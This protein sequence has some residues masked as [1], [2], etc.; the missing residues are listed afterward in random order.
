M[1]LLALLLCTVATLAVA[2]DKPN[3]LFLFADDQRADAV[4]AFNPAV[5]T[6]TLDSL[7]ERGFAFTN[8]HC[9][10][11][12]IPAICTPSRNMLLSGRAYFRWAPTPEALKA[13][14]DLAPADGPNFAVAFKNAGYQTYHHGKKGNTALNIQATFE[15]NKYLK[16]DEAERTSG[17]PGKEI[18][19]DAI[20]FLRDR[21]AA[22]DARPFFMYLA[23]ANPHDP[24]VAHDPYMAQYD[25]AKIP[26]P[27]NYLPQHPWNIGSNTV[28][29]ELLAPFPRTPEDIRKH[30]H[31]YYAVITCFDGYL[32]KILA[33]V[34]ELGLDKNTIV[35]FSADHGLGMGSHGLMGKQNIY[36]TGMKA[37]LIFAG[38]GVPHGRSDAMCY[39]L[40]ILPTAVDLAGA[41]SPKDIDG[42]SLRPVIEGRQPQVRDSLFLA[43]ID[44]QR[45]V[46]D[47]RWK[48]IVYPKIAK[49]ELFDLVSD[50]DEMKNLAD[51]PG[52][53]PRIES[54][55]A[56]LR[57]WQQHLGDTTPLKVEN[58]EPAEFIAP[59]K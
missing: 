27:K 59:K 54:L 36:E 20:A 39:L 33:T 25:E 30:L 58:P 5:K 43:Y 6:P 50:P 28:R 47:E 44:S 22:R 4:G 16:N 31:D 7:V 1:R 8:A 51:D 41:A 24:R 13:T 21:T 55:T 37:P 9:L 15:I 10:G 53:A 46:R 56:K 34:R 17:E 42:K 45:A 35:I 3:V 38:P 19:D 40:D 48:L 52:Q 32:G 23:F 26:L 57:G 12:N 49:R 11:G 29:D 14:K 18:A 2:A